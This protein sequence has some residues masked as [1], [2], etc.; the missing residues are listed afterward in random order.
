MLNPATWRQCVVAAAVE[1]VPFSV[2]NRAE[3]ETDVDEIEGS[4]ESEGLKQE[5]DVSIRV[6]VKI[7]IGVA[8]L[9]LHMSSTSRMQFGGTQSFG[10]GK[11]SIPR[12]IACGKRSATSMAFLGVSKALTLAEADV[13]I[14]IPMLHLPYLGQERSGVCLPSLE[15]GIEG[16]SAGSP[17]SNASSDQQSK[18]RTV[19]HR[20]AQST[21]RHV[22]IM[23]PLSFLQ[24]W[25]Y[26]PGLSLL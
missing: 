8:R 9:T 23:F 21:A 20:Q 1:G 26:V 25:A 5:L 12:T 24:V 22:S 15:R 14:H 6:K 18:T 16:S 19:S 7:K 17:E 2:G 10:G 4:F 11:R 3:K 13:Y